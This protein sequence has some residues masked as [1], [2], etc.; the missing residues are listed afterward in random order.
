VFQLAWRL[1][2]RTPAQFDR[3]RKVWA[4]AIQIDEHRIEV[5]AKDH[6]RPVFHPKLD[7]YGDSW[8]R[9]LEATTT[10]REVEKPT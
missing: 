4:N 10:G 2:V 8:Q 1:D 5:R 7:F 3:R 9:K 6:G